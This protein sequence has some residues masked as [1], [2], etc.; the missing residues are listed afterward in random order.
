M[1]P[2]RQ[3]MV[4]DMKIRSFKGETRYRYILAIEKFAQH[5]AR[6]PEHLSQEHVREFLVCLHETG[7]SYAVISQYIAAL[8]FLL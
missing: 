5:F 4:E 8:R 6:S 2:L 7:A 3:R 1:T